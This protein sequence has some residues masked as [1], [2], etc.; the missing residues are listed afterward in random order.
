[1]LVYDIN[2]YR[3]SLQETFHISDVYAY[4]YPPHSLFLASFFALFPYGIALG[5]WTA[6]GLTVFWH[7]AR[8]YLAEAG[9]SSAL[10]LVLPAGLVS[11]WAGHYGLLVGALGLYGWRFIDCQPRSEEHTSE[12]QSLMRI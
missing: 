12:L 10:A 1:M 3:K 5:L 11:I 8:P 4:S 9:L 2:G 6:I 7:A